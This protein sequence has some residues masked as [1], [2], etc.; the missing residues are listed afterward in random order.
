MNLDLLW[1]GGRELVMLDEC[2]VVDGI[3]YSTVYVM[4]IEKSVG[5]GCKPTP[6]CCTETPSR[7][8]SPAPI[9]F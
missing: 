9:V 7:T 1:K 3:L 4:Y 5:A 8:R 2:R 6:D